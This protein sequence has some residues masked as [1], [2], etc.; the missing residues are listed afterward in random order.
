MMGRIVGIGQD[1][2]IPG[3]LGGGRSGQQIGAGA[4]RSIGA[5]GSQEGAG[6]SQ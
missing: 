3:N 5:Q 4:Q 1:M 6:R 2:E